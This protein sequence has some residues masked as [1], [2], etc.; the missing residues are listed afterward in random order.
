M[1]GWIPFIAAMLLNM[2]FLGDVGSA[3]IGLTGLMAFLAL[4]KMM[5]TL[6]K[7]V[8][9]AY[10]V[11][12][13]FAVLFAMGGSTVIAVL[14]LGGLGLGQ[15][16]FLVADI[17]LFVGLYIGLMHGVFPRMVQPKL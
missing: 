3:I 17:L 16:A 15:M 5:G 11:F 9:M 7:S 10:L 6:C 4:P 2:V 1:V 12:T 13:F 8:P 14:A